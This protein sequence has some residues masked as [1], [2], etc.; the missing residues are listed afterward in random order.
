MFTINKTIL[1]SFVALI[2]FPVHAQQQYLNY[3]SQQLPQT[4]YVNA[5]TMLPCKYYVGIP[6]ISS[7]RFNAAHN[8]FNLKDLYTTTQVNGIQEL[9]IDELLKQFHNKNLFS[10]STE[11]EWLSVGYQFNN[12]CIIF[13]INEILQ[14][15]FIYPESLIQLF[16][17][18]NT[19]FE[20][21]KVSSRNLGFNASH[22][23]QYSLSYVKK[24][25]NGN[26]LGVR[27]KLLFGKANFSVNQPNIDLYTN[28]VSFN[29]LLNGEIT[30]NTAVLAN[31]NNSEDFVTPPTFNNNIPLNEYLLSRKNPGIAFDIGWVKKISSDREWHLSLNNLGFIKWSD[32]T[33]N[34]QFKGDYTYEGFA[35]VHASPYRQVVNGIYNATSTTISNNSYTTWLPASMTSG[36]KQKYNQWLNYGIHY[37]AVL[38]QRKISNSLTGVAEIQPSRQINLLLS[39]T[40]HQYSFDNLGAGFILNLNPVQFYLLSD[41]IIGIISPYTTRNINLRCGFNLHFGCKNK[42]VRHKSSGINGNCSWAEKQL[43]KQIQKEKLK[44]R[45]H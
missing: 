37:Q 22:Y 12:Q 38:F 30:I 36:I 42:T 31:F 4:S 6:A 43:Q 2:W 5:A 26:Q 29:L 40:L 39:Y 9:D 11:I 15:A 7:I 1:I 45:N 10:I 32:N 21:Q 41:N 28:D 18:G 35:N 23:R 33:N 3:F 25:T 19:P 20:G 24:T 8:A 13:G 34:I 14:A 27:A 17:D 16:S 44:S